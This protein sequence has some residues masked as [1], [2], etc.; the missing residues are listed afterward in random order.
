MGDHWMEWL[1]WA[2]LT[3]LLAQRI[4]FRTTQA[5]DDSPASVVEFFPLP[6]TG[7]TTMLQTVAF[8]I[9]TECPPGACVCERER[10][11]ADPAADLRILKLTR[12]EE[13][14]LLARIE[15]ISSYEDL[16]RMGQRMHQLLGIAL[17]IVPGPNEVRT[18]RGF[19]IELG[20]LPG[21]C[22][23][24]KQSIPAAVRRCLDKH[25]EIAFAILDE[26]GLFGVGLPEQ[27]V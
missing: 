20:E 7:S 8:P 9:R 4:D 5:R 23:K 24:T 11:L 17:T 13:K 16:R 15:A 25:P 18:V 22:R 10:L 14:K 2:G 19:S 26:Y 6:L 12:E 27:G 1:I 3:V 21:M